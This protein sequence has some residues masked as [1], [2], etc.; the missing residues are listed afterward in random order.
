MAASDLQRDALADREAPSEMEIV[1]TFTKLIFGEE[2]GLCPTEM[3]IVRVLR[4]VDDNVALDSLAGMG[5][6]LRALDV[7][8]M[9]GLVDRVRRNFPPRVVRTHISASLH[10][11]A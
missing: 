2:E 5:V 3:A 8:E 1:D 9:I 11:P 4:Q 6:Y 10:Q 7:T